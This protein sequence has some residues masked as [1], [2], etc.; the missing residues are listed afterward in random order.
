M[1]KSHFSTPGNYR[2]EVEGI[3]PQAWFE[4]LAAMWVLEK[5]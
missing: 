1:S 5:A 3:L 2:I 4:C